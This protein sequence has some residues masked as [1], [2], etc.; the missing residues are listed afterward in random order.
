MRLFDETALL[1]LLPLHVGRA[2]GSDW[3]Q[4]C[5]AVSVTPAM[6]TT[7][8]ILVTFLHCSALGRFSQQ[9]NKHRQL[10]ESKFQSPGFRVLIS[11]HFPGSG[12]NE[13]GRTFSEDLDNTFQIPKKRILC[14]PEAKGVNFNQLVESH[15]VLEQT[16]PMWATHWQHEI[17]GFVGARVSCIFVTTASARV[18]SGLPWDGLPQQV[19]SWKPS[20]CP[21]GMVVP[22]CQQWAYTLQL[23]PR[24]LMKCKCV[25]VTVGISLNLL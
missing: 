15:R 7:A 25:G 11:D 12:S 22:S 3:G 10:P 18:G 23:L 24:N 21:A 14:N 1:S 2:K 20:C 17:Q 8:P 9:G 16:W 6:G 19:S 5:Q 13:S 4:R